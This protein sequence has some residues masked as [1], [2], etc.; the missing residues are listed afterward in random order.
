MAKISDS[1]WAKA[2]ALFEA[3]KSFREIDEA[4]GINY[5]SVERTSKKEAWQKGIL[6]QLISD[7]TRVEAEF[8]TLE[9]AQA[10]VVTNEVS[11]RLKHIDWF[12]KAGLKVASM[13]VKS[14]G[15]DPK[16]I[17]C[18]IVADTLVSTMKVT[19]VVSYYPAATSI[20]NN[21]LNAQQNIDSVQD[22]I[23]NRVL[24]G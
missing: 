2:R 16:P 14:M 5:K 12:T 17:D 7:K 22:E 11:E 8:V 20:T 24:N 23:L 15:S 19:G 3:G 13:A 1:D 4:T 10:E 21:N 9:S 6:S 18:K